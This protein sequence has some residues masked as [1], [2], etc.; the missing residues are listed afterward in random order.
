MV[1]PKKWPSSEVRKW[2]TSRLPLTNPY[3][4]NSDTEIHRCGTYSFP[5]TSTEAM[6]DM[7]PF[8]HLAVVEAGFI[9]GG[10][11]HCFRSHARILLGGGFK[12]FLF[13]PLPGEMIQFDWYFSDG[14]KPPTSYDLHLQCKIQHLR[15]WT[16]ACCLSLKGT[17]NRKFNIDTCSI[18]LTTASMFCRKLLVADFLEIGLKQE[19]LGH[20]MS[21]DELPGTNGIGQYRRIQWEWNLIPFDYFTIPQNHG[22]S[23]LPNDHQIPWYT[24]AVQ[25]QL[26]LILKGFPWSFRGSF[27]LQELGTS[28]SAW[29]MLMLRFSEATRL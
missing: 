28:K 21:I 22:L 15:S 26:P 18:F 1:C 12:M 25:S 6:V 10:W 7:L 27:F 19:I 2:V 8:L 20:Q 23:N 16:W 3:I 29:W 17:N 13:S 9:M 24:L 14:L 11:R 5:S 4:N